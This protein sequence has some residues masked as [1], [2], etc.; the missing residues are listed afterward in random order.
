M[1]DYRFIKIK[2]KQGFG[3]VKPEKDYHEIVEE[4]AS[5][6]WRLVQIF[7]PPLNGPGIAPYIELI[8]EKERSATDSSSYLFQQTQ[9]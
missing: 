4:Y 3:E 5:L 9:G 2:T 7:A 1:Y 6:G 8:F